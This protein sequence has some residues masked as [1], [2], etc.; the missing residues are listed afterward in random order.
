MNI[1]LLA[2]AALSCLEVIK[3]IPLLEGPSRQTRAND[4]IIIAP[5]QT[6]VPCDFPISSKHERFYHHLVAFLRTTARDRPDPRLSSRKIVTRSIL[7]RFGF[8]VIR[9]INCVCYRRASSIFPRAMTVENR[10]WDATDWY[11][12]P[13]TSGHWC[14]QRAIPHPTHRTCSSGCRHQVLR[15][16][17]DVRLPHCG[18]ILHYPC[19]SPHVQQACYRY[20]SRS[21]VT[22]TLARLDVSKR[23]SHWSFQDPPISTFPSE[24]GRSRRELRRN[25]ACDSVTS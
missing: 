5:F 25:G 8:T 3:G 20:R 9:P 7:F 13:P 12:L 19:I 1:H 15:A 17:R 18:L 4:A 16:Q 2:A 11:V 21:Y 14:C 10:P 6:D 22:I 24:S 23:R